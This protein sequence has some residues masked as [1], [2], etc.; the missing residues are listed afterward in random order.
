M[1]DKI[2]EIQYLFDFI[3]KHQLDRV[4]I[5][6]LK[7]VK[8][9]EYTEGPSV[10]EYLQ[11]ISRIRIKF[12][13]LEIIAGTNLRR[14]EEAGYLMQAGAN[15]ITKFP[16]TK[17]FG[18]KKAKLIEK[19]IMDEKREFRSNLTKIEGIE[20]EKEIDTL[21]INKEYKEEMKEKLPAYL[22]KFRNPVDVDKGVSE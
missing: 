10:E 9:T 8:G 20:W 16:A 17:Q 11:W 1:G 18:T 4:T 12:P 6:A 7:P 14:C 19:L 5:Y 22:K 21:M 3:D 15:A 2:E 13:K